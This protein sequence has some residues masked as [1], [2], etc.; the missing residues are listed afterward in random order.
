MTARHALDNDNSKLFS[1]SKIYAMN[2]PAPQKPSLGYE[3]AGLKI[4]EGNRPIHHN[5]L[6]TH[7]DVTYAFYGDEGLSYDKALTH[8]TLHGDE[9]YKL[10]TP[11]MKEM[12]KQ[13]LQ[14]WSDVADITFRP[15]TDPE[16]ADIRFGE[17]GYPDKDHGAWLGFGGGVTIFYGDRA[18][19]VWVSSYDGI[20]PE[21]RTPGS[22]ITQGYTHEIGHALGLSHPGHYNSGS[23]TYAKDAEYAE[24]S[25]TYS[26]MSYFSDRETGQ[27]FKGPC[28]EGPMLHDI[29]AIQ[30]LYG[31]NMHTRTG[32][33]TYGFNSNADRV[34]MQ[35]NSPNDKVVFSVWDAG[36][37]NTFDFSGYR[38]DQKIDL[39]E[40]ALSDVGGAIGNVSIAKGTHIQK[41]IGG[42]GNDVLIGNDDHNTIIGNGGNNLIYGGK[43]GDIL[44]GGSGHNTYLYGSMSDS[45]VDDPDFITNFKTGQDKIDL[46]GLYGGHN[47]AVP[48][49][50][51]GH[52]DRPGA[53]YSAAFY[54]EGGQKM[55][56]LYIT[57]D[58]HSHDHDDMKIKIAGDFSFDDIVTFPA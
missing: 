44:T 30:H 57:L 42:L 49:A 55:T 50:S 43:G 3:A 56:D 38:Q 29:S 40:T 33:T 13:C 46:S 32:D 20:N 52:T 51:D 48:Y 19:E 23:A 31:A 36:G 1:T 17:H 53:V 25:H 9:K 58:D 22:V 7:A 5:P 11:K 26:I 35:I 18:P 45:T 6:G 34:D 28:A 10:F 12:V 21:G 37:Y 41:V 24:D 14:S 16:K 15:A 54:T 2:A 27:D 39:H 4:A 8:Y 47:A